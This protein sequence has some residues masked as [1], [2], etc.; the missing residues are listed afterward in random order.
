M[1]LLGC[2]SA[3]VEDA[4]QSCGEKQVH[5]LR[6]AIRRFGQALRAFESFFSPHC[7][8]RLKKRLKKMMVLAGGVRNLDVAIEYTEN[9]KLADQEN[10][11]ERRAG[12]ASQLT[13][14]LKRWIERGWP[15]FELERRK[16][17]SPEL[18]EISLQDHARGILSA[19]SKEFFERGN[20]AAAIGATPTQMHGFRI[21]AKKFRYTM[22]LFAPA[23]RPVLDARISQVRQLQSVLGDVNDC[24][25]L[26]TILS[27]D[28]A[29]GKLRKKQSRKVSE[30][31]KKWKS[32]FNNAAVMRQCVEDLALLSERKGPQREHHCRRVELRTENFGNGRRRRAAG[33]G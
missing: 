13:H 23:Y 22:E 16:V 8:K 17:Q 32:Q 14:S 9:W 15:A 6:V 10:L 11:T 20:A 30:F 24:A 5:D 27:G 28:V 19:M 26:R 31:R 4:I 12:A 25:T 29:A 21:A 1:R 33:G 7:S 3:K 2:V 18:D